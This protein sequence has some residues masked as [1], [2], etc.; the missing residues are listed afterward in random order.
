MSQFYKRSPCI[1]MENKM[2]TITKSEWNKTPKD[3]KT[4]IDGQRYI[5]LLKQG[6]TSL[7][8]VNVVKSTEGKNDKQIF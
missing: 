1:N 4:T 7:V 8:P 5:L 6:G 3:Y 2:L